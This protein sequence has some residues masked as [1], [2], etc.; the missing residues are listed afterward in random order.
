MNMDGQL[1]SAAS[2]GDVKKLKAL[3]DAGGNVNYSFRLPHGQRV[4]L[5]QTTLTNGKLDCFDLLLARGVSPNASIGS[6]PALCWTAA[7]GK[8]TALSIL[9]D[10]LPDMDATSPH[11]KSKVGNVYRPVYYSAWQEALENGHSEIIAMLDRHINYPQLSKIAEPVCKA[12]LFEKNARGDCL[13][14]NPATW[15]D[16]PR[17]LADLAVHGESLGLQDL[18]RHSVDGRSWL[19]RA[20]ECNQ[21][22][23]LLAHLNEQGQGLHAAELLAEDGGP[24]DV[25]EKII[26]KQQ[27]D[28]LFVPQNWMT[29]TTKQ[30]VDFYQALPQEERADIRNIHQLRIS[31]DRQRVSQGVSA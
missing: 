1:N 19:Q 11:Y 17:V 5:I 14:D 8:E 15:R 29:T 24:N 6:L 30:L 18:Q 9:L 25:L 28:K 2:L 26:R 22:S 16:L 20:V 21:L 4:S 3:L 10:Y 12:Q 23:P 7:Y 13:L 27:I 31:I